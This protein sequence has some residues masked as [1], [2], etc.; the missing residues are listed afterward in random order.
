MTDK[1]KVDEILEVADEVLNDW[2]HLFID[3]MFFW[4]GEY[5]PNQK[6]QIDRI[7]EKVCNSPY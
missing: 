1:Q 6:K 7:Y 2:E 3:D 4:I 5:R